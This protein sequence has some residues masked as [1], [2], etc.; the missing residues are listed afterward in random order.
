MGLH[1]ATSLYFSP[2]RP[3][4]PGF[5]ISPPPL[6]WAYFIQEVRTTTEC[7]SSLSPC[8]IPPC[9]GSVAL[10]VTLGTLVGLSCLESAVAGIQAYVFRVLST[11]YVREADS[12]HLSKVSI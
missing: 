6:G 10:G 9:V 3:P 4:T 11:L 7:V 12:Q 2:F 1:G 8:R 5:F